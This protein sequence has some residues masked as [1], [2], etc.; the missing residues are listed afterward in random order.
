MVA[1][2]GAAS[3]GYETDYWHS[4]VDEEIAADFCDLRPRSMQNFRQKGGGPRY[5]RISSRCVK[6]RR[7][8]LK[9]WADAR[10]RTSTAD[11]GEAE[12]GHATM[13]REA[14]E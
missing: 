14:C 12:Q 10:V 11:D 3:A 6:Y 2:D 5:I 4:L 1:L 8:D 13:I 7:I 9:K